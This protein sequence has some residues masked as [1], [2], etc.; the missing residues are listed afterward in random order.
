MCLHISLHHYGKAS[1][2]AVSPGLSSGS[3]SNGL[4]DPREAISLGMLSSPVCELVIHSACLIQ[5]LF[6][7]G[8]NEMRMKTDKLTT[9]I[10]HKRCLVDL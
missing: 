1:G 9:G 6:G 2:G 10:A 8:L 3:A 7:R 5:Q 4:N